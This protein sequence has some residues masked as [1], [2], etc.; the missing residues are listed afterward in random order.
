[1]LPHCCKLL[2]RPIYCRSIFQEEP[3]PGQGGVITIGIRM[4][5]GVTR[6]RRFSEDAPMA[7]V[8]DWVMTLEEVAVEDRMHVSLLEYP[9]RLLPDSAQ[10]MAELQLPARAMVLLREG[11]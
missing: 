3:E 5:H 9:S 7:A 8:Y 4:G 6:Q 11:L 1:M 2:Q 10:T